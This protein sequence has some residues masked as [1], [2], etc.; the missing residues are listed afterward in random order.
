MTLEAFDAAAG[1]PLDLNTLGSGE[2]VMLPVCLLPGAEF[3][4]RTDMVLGQL[5]GTDPYLT[6]DLA[7]KDLL[8]ERSLVT[9][10]E[11]CELTMPHNGLYPRRLT[12]ADAEN[13]RASAAML[14]RVVAAHRHALYRGEDFLQTVQA[15]LPPPL[16]E[17]PPLTFW[18]KKWRW[19]KGWLP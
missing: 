2:L 10:L 13:L 19:L 8:G 4:D 14:E 15:Q 16:M 12:A 6:F 5:M 1:E 7:D 18:Q 9:F 11:P 17:E 3:A